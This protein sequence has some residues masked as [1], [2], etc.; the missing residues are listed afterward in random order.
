MHYLVQNRA[1]AY[2]TPNL[3]VTFGDDFK[4]QRA[5]HQFSNMDLLISA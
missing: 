5:E 3:L 2:R 1:Q 4:F